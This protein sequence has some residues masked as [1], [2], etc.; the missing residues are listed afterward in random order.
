[1]KRDPKL[2]PKENDILCE[3]A[4]IYHVWNIER[5]K[6]RT[7]I[8]YHT[9]ASLETEWLSLDGWKVLVRD[10]VVLNLAE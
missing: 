7:I 9:S 2:A 4:T 10:A 6:D 1:M 5:F 8:Y 3:K